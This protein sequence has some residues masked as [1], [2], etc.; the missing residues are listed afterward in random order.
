MA[1]F[2]DEVNI[3][4][5]RAFLFLFLTLLA[6]CS[7]AQPNVISPLKFFG[8]S[9]GEDYWL[10]NYKQLTDYFKKVDAESDRVKVVSIG[11]TEEKREQ[12]MAIISSPGNIRN[13]EKYR[14]IARKLALGE[15]KDEVEAK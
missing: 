11:Q 10:A 3:M 4:L 12:I 2:A 1:W 14:T 7:F 5:R 6:A 8:H 15:V 9:I 13:L